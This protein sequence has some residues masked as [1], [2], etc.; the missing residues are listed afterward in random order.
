MDLALKKQHCIQLHLFQCVFPHV[1]TSTGRRVATWDVTLCSMA[2][3]ALAD[4]FQDCRAKPTPKYDDSCLKTRGFRALL[5]LLLVQE[6]TRDERGT[7]HQIAE[8][9]P[10]GIDEEL[11]TLLQVLSQ[12]G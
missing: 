6:N 8:G 10:M 2:S 4:N 7:A 1:V 9:L 3:Y 11:P 12:L 5:D